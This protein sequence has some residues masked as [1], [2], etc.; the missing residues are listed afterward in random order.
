MAEEVRRIEPVNNRGGTWITFGLE[1]YR[2][3]A[4]GLRAVRELQDRIRSMSSMD[5]LPT[6]EQMDTVFE[7]AHA[8]LRRNYPDISK[9]VV[10]DMIDLSNFHEVLAAVMAISGF[11]PREGGASGETVAST[12]TGSTSP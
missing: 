8:A 2:V 5:G 1:A 7:I 4:L 6:A 10:A 3:P 12:G 11:A 9:D